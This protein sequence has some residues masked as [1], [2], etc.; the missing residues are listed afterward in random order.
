MTQEALANQLP[1]RPDG[2]EVDLVDPGGDGGGDTNGRRVDA[3]RGSAL[4]T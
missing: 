4:S 2:D 3:F 1:V